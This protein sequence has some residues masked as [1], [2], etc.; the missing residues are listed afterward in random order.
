M[1]A[2][3]DVPETYNFKPV[4]LIQVHAVDSTLLHVVGFAARPGEE[5]PVAAAVARAADAAGVELTLPAVLAVFLMLA[6]VRSAV[7]LAT[8]GASDRDASGLHRPASREALRRRRGSEVGVSSSRAAD[9]TCSMLLTERRAPHRPGCVPPAA[10][11]GDG[12]AGA[13]RRSCSPR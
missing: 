8:D 10:T 4:D 1:T 11:G 13:G 2:E 6:A 12:A 9:P 7:A 5:S 3:K